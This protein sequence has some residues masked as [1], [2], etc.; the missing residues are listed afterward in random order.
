MLLEKG[1]DGNRQDR[2]GETPFLNAAD[3]CKKALHEY[4]FKGDMSTTDE[5]RDKAFLEEEVKE[6]RLHSDAAKDSMDASRTAAKKDDDKEEKSGLLSI[7]IERTGS[8]TEVD[9]Y[10]QRAKYLKDCDAYGN[11]DVYVVVQIDG[12]DGPQYQRTSTLKDAGDKPVWEQGRGE[13]L[14][15]ADVPPIFEDIIFRVYDEDYGGD[16][17]DDLIGMHKIPLAKIKSLRGTGED[18]VWEADVQLRQ[19]REMEKENPPQTTERYKPAV[20]VD[21]AGNEIAAAV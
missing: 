15:F 19:N 10:I 4:G 2:D 13:K 7:K 6:G 11:N 5:A 1:A 14:A 8:G 16:S 9:F 17:T 20:A 21:E 3:S 12:P 18:F